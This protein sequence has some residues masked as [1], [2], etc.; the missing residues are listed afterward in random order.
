MYFK[1]TYLLLAFLTLSLGACRKKSATYTV[2][3]TT[4]DANT[5]RIWIGD[6]K[7][8]G[9]KLSR[10][11]NRNGS[12]NSGT[13]K[14]DEEI[15]REVK[16]W[17]VKHFDS[18][19]SKGLINEDDAVLKSIRIQY[20]DEYGKMVDIKYF[21]E[22]VPNISGE[23]N[24]Y[25]VKNYDFTE[26]RIGNRYSKDFAIPANSILTV[27]ALAAQSKVAVPVGD[28]PDLLYGIIPYGTKIDNAKV[29]VK[30]EIFKDGE[31]VASNKATEL[32]VV[33]VVATTNK[34]KK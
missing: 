22:E 14:S 4:T 18:L 15:D 31:I 25:Y 8:Y 2:K 24:E 19:S 10:E 27:T 28:D 32:K 29:T 21:G 7:A 1:K 13:S 6:A 34:S 23:S 30:I 17:I 11:N 26:L 9:D 12:G 3:I 33:E 5:A 16:N 20:K